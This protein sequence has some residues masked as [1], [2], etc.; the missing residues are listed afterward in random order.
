MSDNPIIGTSTGTLKDYDVSLSKNLGKFG[1]GEAGRKR[2]EV[3]AELHKGSELIYEKDGEWQVSGIRQEGL[4][5][6]YNE[7]SKDDEITLKDNALNKEGIANP[8]ISFVEN[9]K[10]IRDIQIMVNSPATSPETLDKIANDAM[11]SL[12]SEDPKKDLLA[13]SHDFYLLETIISNKS[14]LRETLNKIESFTKDMS[15][16]ISNK[17]N[18]ASVFNGKNILENNVRSMNYLHTLSSPPINNKETEKKQN[19]FY[20]EIEKLKKEIF[21]LKEEI[22]ELDINLDKESKEIYKVSKELK[23]KQL[24]K[25]NELKG[26]KFSKISE[27]K[28]KQFTQINK[29]KERVTSLEIENKKLIHKNTEIKGYESHHQDKYSRGYEIPNY[30]PNL[31]MQQLENINY[32]FENKIRDLLFKV[33]DL[34]SENKELSKEN[35]NL[36]ETKNFW[37]ENSPFMKK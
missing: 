21:G 28:E 3:A 4:I 7:I 37:I 2:A 29:L 25:I 6:G 10:S 1:A 13:D 5:H 14:T 36:Q 26:K 24:S 15:T 32:M 30:P 18:N 27:L 17:F 20:S 22:K 34:E 16:K 11:E 9:D 12:E 31:E 19:E 35:I 8:Q 33:Y 23:G